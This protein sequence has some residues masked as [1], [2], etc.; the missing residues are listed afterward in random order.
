M[1]NS[2]RITPLSRIAHL[3]DGAV[4][5]MRQHGNAEQADRLA[6]FW[7]PAAT[8]ASYRSGG[9][10]VLDLLGQRPRYSDLA[11]RAVD[12][13]EVR[14]D[15]AAQGSNPQPALTEGGVHIFF[16]QDQRLGHAAGR[17]VMLS[18]AARALP[19]FQTRSPLV[20]PSAQG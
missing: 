14:I 8:A 19:P 15:D 1:T 6:V 20:R 17:M 4:D 2:A 9:L 18:P 10:V 12:A 5:R 7:R 3:V 16:L 11:K 13:V